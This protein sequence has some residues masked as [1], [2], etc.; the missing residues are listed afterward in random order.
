MKEVLLIIDP[1]E[2]FAEEENGIGGALAVQ[3]GRKALN[4]VANFINKYGRQLDDIIVTMDCHN[5]L[6]IAHPMWFQDENGHEPAP[7]K[8]VMEEAGEMLIGSLDA[9]GQFTQEG[10]VRCRQL[11]FTSWTLSY[12][13]ALKT[14]GRYPHM[15]W[16]PHC[17]IGSPGNAVVPP[18]LSAVQ[19]W[20]RT[21]F[22]VAPKITKGSNLKTEHF[23][24]LRAEVADPR[25]PSTQVNS[26]FLSLLSDPDTTIYGCGLALGHCLANTARDV[27]AEFDEDTFCERFVLLRDGTEHVAGLEFLGDS[28]V[29]DFEARGMRVVNTTDF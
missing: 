16:P 24:A 28:F 15:L 26:Y 25:D 27:A 9:S 10:K 8:T 17:L 4:N 22:A 29:K 6:H 3:G 2:D 1:Q 19:N 20:E 5:V 11:A 13:R 23:G 21:E 7:F 14:G 18:V 12:L